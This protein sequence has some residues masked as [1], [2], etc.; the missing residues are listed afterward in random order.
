VIRLALAVAA[1]CAVVWAAGADLGALAPSD[2]AKA[3]IERTA[4]R[5]ARLA[6]DKLADEVAQLLVP[7]NESTPPGA[8]RPLAANEELGEAT[9]FAP[10]PELA[11]EAKSS[12]KPNPKPNRWNAPLDADQAEA[13]RC[14]LDRVMSLA[15]GNAE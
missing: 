13:V 14:R 5:T 11:A 4:Q 15:A 9:H 2:D 7:A 8:M 10:E 12:P 1:A 6:R 3:A